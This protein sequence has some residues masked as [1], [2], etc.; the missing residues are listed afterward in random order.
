MFAQM[1]AAAAA[2]AQIELKPDSADKSQYAFDITDVVTKHAPVVAAKHDAGDAI[3]IC[4]YGKFDVVHSD[5]YL[6]FPDELLNKLQ[7]N[8]GRVVSFG[9]GTEI[10]AL[11]VKTRL[12]YVM[13]L[14][15]SIAK[16]NAAGLGAFDPKMGFVS[17][18]VHHKKQA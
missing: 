1:A 7:S 3:V 12:C 13:T 6:D 2:A 9:Q 17:A 5:V 16:L 14:P 4:F 11:T 15:E 18:V 8:G 10:G